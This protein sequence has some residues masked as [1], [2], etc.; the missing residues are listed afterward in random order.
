MALAN[1]QAVAGGFEPGHYL[2][3]LSIQNDGSGHALI[4]LENLESGTKHLYYVA[5]S[6]SAEIR[7]VPV[8]RYSLSFAMDG[9]LAADCV[10]LVSA[11]MVVRF[12]EPF[13]FTV[14]EKYVQTANEFY[15]DIVVMNQWA[16][17]FGV[18]DGN[19]PSDAITIE[20][21]NR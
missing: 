17:L 15:T 12:E 9:R 10:T 13:E 1:G 3:E 19:G 4:Q 18:E 21:F 8:G 6:S 7:F 20:D 5:R 14:E 2:P 16:T 11:K